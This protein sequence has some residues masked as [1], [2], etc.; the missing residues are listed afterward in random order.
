MNFVENK[1]SLVGIGLYTPSEAAQL[2]GVSAPKITRWLRGHSIGD[3]TYEP[4]WHSQVNLEDG[5]TYLGFRDLMEVRVADAFIQQ[6][7]L[8]HI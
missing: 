5:H 7:S 8:I 1:A 6:L 4:L 3:K 2:I